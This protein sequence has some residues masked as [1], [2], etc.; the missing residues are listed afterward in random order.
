MEDIIIRIKA[1][2][3]QKCTECDYRESY[4]FYSHLVKCPKC[5]KDSIVGVYSSELR[6]IYVTKSRGRYYLNKNDEAFSY[7][8]YNLPSDKF[9][10]TRTS[11]VVEEDIPED[12]PLEM[13]LE[14]QTIYKSYIYS[15]SVAEIKKLVEYLES[16]EDEQYALRLLARKENAERKLYEIIQ[17]LPK[18]EREQ[19]LN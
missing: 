15:S 17:K 6:P 16:V 3:T 18:E 10:H 11:F 1:P 5:N 7:C 12:S 14:I 4:S 19:I 2:I 9:P 13:A 8:F